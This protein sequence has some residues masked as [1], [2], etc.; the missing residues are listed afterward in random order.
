MAVCYFPGSSKATNSTALSSAHAIVKNLSQEY[1]TREWTVKARPLRA[2]VIDESNRYL[3]ALLE[4][5]RREQPTSADDPNEREAG[6]WSLFH[7]ALENSAK[8]ALFPSVT[9]SKTPRST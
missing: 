5:S 4:V 7:A 2:S 3:F 6:H 1:A 8:A 9:D